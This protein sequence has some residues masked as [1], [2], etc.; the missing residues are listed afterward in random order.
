MKQWLTVLMVALLAGCA[1]APPTSRV[2]H[3]FADRLFTAPVAPVRT[4]D[5]FALS[6][7]M[8]RYLRADIGEQ[9]RTKGRALGLV[10]AL[11]TAGKL[12]LEYDSVL[13]RNAAEAFEARAGNCLSLVI[14][15]AA[16]A[17]ELDLTVRYKSV[18]VED[19]WSREGDLFFVNGHVNLS[20]ADRVSDPYLGL[21]DGNAM[22]VDFMPLP[23]N[24]RQNARTIG[25]R[26]V[27]AMYLNNRAAE[28]LAR[29]QIDEAYWWAREAMLQDPGF[30]AAHN[31]LGVIYRHHHNAAEAEAV[32]RDVLARDPAN[33]IAM[34][35]LSRVLDD[36][37]RYEESQL[38][39]NKV[40]SLQPYPPYY[41]FDLGMAAMRARQYA[42]AR[43]LF[44][45][46]VDRAGYNPEFHFWLASAHAALGEWA[47]AQKHLMVAMETSNNRRDHDIY[48]AKLGRIKASGQAQAGYRGDP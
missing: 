2:D 3:L 17:R 34:S 38:L 24:R 40:A 10:D 30:L 47:P 22:V 41:Y 21:T 19:A 9:L 7:E 31:T 18:A 42:A 14:M 4:E 5:I 13:T 16:L 39:A 45:R 12:K 48:A 15:T 6:P 1:S 25:E 36:L 37:G 43:D 29:D 46:E 8:K 32:F 26:T 35:N 23:P 44:A 20:L 33:L 11:Y 27:V 28:K